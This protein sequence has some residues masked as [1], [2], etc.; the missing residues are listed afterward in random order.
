M[1][2]ARKVVEVLDQAEED[3][4]AFDRDSGLIQPREQPAR[5][6]EIPHTRPRGR[7][8]PVRQADNIYD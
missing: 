8:A 1:G 5:E 6:L 7:P 3:D 4:W 2:K